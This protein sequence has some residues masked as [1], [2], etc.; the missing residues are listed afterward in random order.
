MANVV[1][2]EDA[3]RRWEVHDG[4]EFAPNELFHGTGTFRLGHRD[5]EFLDA[6]YKHNFLALRHLPGTWPT[7]GKRVLQLWEHGLIARCKVP[8]YGGERWEYAYSLTDL[9]MECLRFDSPEDPLGEGD[10]KPPFMH[11]GGKAPLQ[12]QLDLADLCTGLER[13]I[14]TRELEVWWMGSGR[15]TIIIPAKNPRQRGVQL[16]PDAVIHSSTPNWLL[17]EL[18]H[19]NRY[20]RVAEHLDGY[21]KMYARKAWENW[22]KPPMVLMSLRD[23]AAT[24]GPA[25]F[26]TA[27]QMAR[28]MP[29]LFGWLYLIREDAWR[30]GT[31][32]AVSPDPDES[33]VNLFDIT[34]R[35]WLGE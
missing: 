18:Q 3:P 9:G 1:R 33:E 12:H 14:R 6:L 2:L 21:A 7:S 24:R 17:I 15:E 10:W 29:A 35:R 30:T 13:Y 11:R 19:D 28:M 27:M 16:H 22:Q 34:T 32:V 8:K 20:Q 23:R 31:W 5:T 26:E 4:S 25:P